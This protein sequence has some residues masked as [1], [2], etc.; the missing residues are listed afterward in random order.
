MS[1]VSDLRAQV[2]AL[3]AT[4]TVYKACLSHLRDL[5][6]PTPTSGI[7]TLNGSYIYG[8]CNTALSAGP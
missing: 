5:T 1:I 4:N 6:K 7:I 8:A 3:T 2:A